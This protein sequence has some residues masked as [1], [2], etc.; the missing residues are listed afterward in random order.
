MKKLTLI[1]VGNGMAGARLVERLCE[2][3]PER[4]HIQIVGE[5]RQPAYNRIQL[6]P[7][8]SGEKG[9][10]DIITHDAPWYA[11]RGVTLI[12]GAP[13]TAIDRDARRIS[14]GDRTLAYDH[15][16]LA[17]GSRAFMPPLPGNDLCGIHGFRDMRDV[18]NILSGE[19]A[20][21]PAVVIGGGVL[22]VEAAAALALRGM[23]VSL[24][25]RGPHLMDAQLD[26]HT[27]ELLRLSLATRGI[28]SVLQAQTAAYLADHSGCVKAVALRDEREIPARRVVVAAGVR[29]EI[30]LARSA[31]LACDRGILVNDRLYTSDPDIS[32]IGECCQQGQLTVGLV[33][34]CWQQ[35]EALAA[36]LLADP[37]ADPIAARIADPIDAPVPAAVSPTLAVRL[38]VT[39][40]D[41]FCAGELHGGENAQI[42]SAS[43][44]FD[45][46]YRRLLLRDNRLAGVVLWGDISDG[47]DYLSR[48]NQTSFSQT[49]PSVFSPGD[50]PADSGPSPV[51]SE[52]LPVE[53]TRSKAMSKPVLVMAGHGM[54]GHHFLQQLVERELHLHYQVIVFAEEKAPAY[55]RVH[56][57]EYFSG[58][59]AESLSMVEDG[60]FESSGIELRLGHCIGHIDTRHRFVVDHQGRQTAYDVLVLATGSYP[61]VPPI[62]GNDAPGC[63]VYR[64]L[65]DL[66]AIQACAAKG[67]TGVVVGGG[68]LGLEAANAL[69]HLGLQT[70]VV[71]FAPRLMGVQLDE[72]GAAMLRRKIEALDVQVH[73]GKETRA[74]VAGETGG[75]RMEFAD[76]G[77]LDTDLVLFSAGI[78]PRDQLARECGLEVGPRGGIVIN[79]SCRTSDP[80]IFAIGECAL[81]NGQIFGLVAPGY[82]M[83][84][85]LADTLA[86]SEVAFK[87]ADMSTKLKL[88]GVEVASVGDAH[89]RTP[90]SQSYSWVD[91]PGE[92]YKKIVVSEDKKRLLGAVLVGDS[93]E[94]STLLQMMLND[95]P[96]PAS[97]EMLI[98]PASSG[99]AP[100]SLGVA[101]L[102]DGAQ[103]CSCHNVSKSDI[104]DAV[105]GGCGDMAAVKACTKAATGCGGCAAL[106]KQVMEFALTEM[107]VEVK[108]DICEHFAFSRQEIYHLVRA[109]NIRSFEELIHK[110]GQGSGCEICKPLAGSIL[111]SCWNDYL[112]KPQHLPLQDTNDRYFANI[113][114]DGTYSVVPR[115]PAGEITP[116]GLIAIGQV[117]KRYN[118]Y[119]K[120]TG[121]QR[122]DL[123]GAR[124]EQ[125]PEIWQQLVDAGFETGHAYG[126]SLR[127]V[128]S[129]VGSNWCRYGVQDST[130]LA[131][132]LENRYKG[133]RSPHKIKMAVSGCT[134][135]CAEAQSKDVGVIATEKGWNLYVCGNGGMKPRHADLLAQD[136]STDDLI[137]TVDRFLM[138]YVRTADRLQRTSTWMDNLEGGLDYL[139]QVVLEDSLHIG[140]ELESEMDAVVGTYQCEWQ[141]TLAE[142]DRLALFRPFV[143]SAEPDEAVVMVTERQQI[144]PATS[145]ERAE[146]P[147]S[148]VAPTVSAVQGWVD[149]CDVQAIP[150]NAGMA[151]RL[152]NRQIALFHLPTHPQQVFA[153]SNHE[154]DSDANVLSRGL[155]G[156]VKGEPVVISPLY[157]QRFRLQDGRSV[158]DGQLALSVW[159]V[160]VE[161]GRVWVQEQPV[162]AAVKTAEIIATVSL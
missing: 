56:L 158:D 102:P 104:C 17:T 86:G 137:R 156:D 122:L 69:K 18:E 53:A 147:A 129:C 120:I 48:I 33:A 8:L 108:K 59:S 155:L 11:A 152:A 73:T 74:I 28:T 21:Q 75:Y 90:G 77:H 84:R 82:Q 9:F 131:L 52:K 25:H 138:F 114:K 124:L 35:A 79:D 51:K 141:T 16:V 22:G 29:P 58:R 125:L 80:A 85:T 98:L 144:R 62:P 23:Q 50:A 127:T 95:M 43:D 32:A 81:W 26:A 146:H 136:M 142:P 103:I 139:R 109:G 99:A 31:G 94:Y 161:N 119:T 113:Q 13:V 54:V 45:G 42:H 46:H 91:G 66:A 60:F 39:G 63:L 106:T 117:A 105:K 34:P 6:T 123:F 148:V 71:E 116:D 92:V 76:G 7:V 160:K 111:A 55:D 65:D 143:N 96:L 159:P 115:I 44:P 5:E 3:A 49:P 135:E 134:R 89:G 30:A 2:R 72:G 132:R 10:D 27:A 128:K 97:P 107:G 36:R 24:L 12:A 15:L 19:V 130:G 101:A 64:T 121:G 100:Q 68:L 157:K 110:H 20:G 40:I 145:Q 14:I 38:K 78:R 153:L 57:S 162:A 47:P 133:L 37:I 93:S 83:A 67:K 4:F 126:K 1:V 61:F 112:L 88:L 70:H 154:P 151:A 150:A 140:A 149:L 87:G 118:L 41:L